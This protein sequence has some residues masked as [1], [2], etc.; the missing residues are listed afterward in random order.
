M[1]WIINRWSITPRNSPYF[2]WA[3]PLAVLFDITGSTHGIDI[4]DTMQRGRLARGVAETQRQG[5]RL[6]LRKR[7]SKNTVCGI[8]SDYAA[9]IGAT[10]SA[11][12]LLLVS[13][14]IAFETSTL[15]DM[16]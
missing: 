14:A 15:I 13:L 1:D 4:D 8:S 6:L 3:L 2:S 7:N 11:I 5:R 10:S 9:L 16:E 12:V